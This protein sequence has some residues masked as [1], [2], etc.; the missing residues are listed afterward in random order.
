MDIRS[1]GYDIPLDFGL[2]PEKKLVLAPP[3]IKKLTIRPTFDQYKSDRVF[4]SPT[5]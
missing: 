1:I 2:Y 4:N 3:I 5:P